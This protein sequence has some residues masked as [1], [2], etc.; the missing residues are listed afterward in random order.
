MGWSG[1][2]DFGREYAYKVSRQKSETATFVLL[3]VF[4]F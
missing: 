2:G 4:C 1:D 3:C